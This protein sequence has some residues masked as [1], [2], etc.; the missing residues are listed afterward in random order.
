MG[1]LDNVIRAGSAVTTGRLNDQSVTI[2]EVLRAA[3]YFTGMAGKWHLGQQNGSPP[4]ERGFDRVLNLRAGGMFFPNQNFQD[5]G[6][7]TQRGQEPLYLDGTAI[8]RDSPA[9]GQNWYSTFLWTD[10][11]LKFVDEARKANKPFFLYVPHNAPHFP[12][13]A[14]QALIA[15]H[16]GRYKTGW[17][18]LREAR[19]RRQVRIGLI[20][21]RWPLSP[22]ETESPAWELLS[23]GQEPVR[24]PHGGVRGHGGASQRIANAR[25][26]G[27]RRLG[28]RSSARAMVSSH[29]AGTSNRRERTR[30]ASVVN[31]FTR[32][33]S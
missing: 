19:Y 30:G 15:K 10:F 6:E 13:M 28:S 20:D 1:H 7:L 5:G 11:G 29:A 18:N 25:A 31:R 21:S 9:L 26:D 16:R 24:P 27:Q 32:I 33:A 14:P 17:D 4:W 8:P 2:A 12:L 23:P 22:R 3:R